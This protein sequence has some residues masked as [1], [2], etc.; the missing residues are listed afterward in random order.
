MTLSHR[1]D[2]GPTY[3][4]RGDAVAAGNESAVL[5]VE[6][7]GSCWLL[8]IQLLDDSCWQH[9]SSPSSSVSIPVNMAATDRQSSPQSNMREFVVEGENG[10]KETRRTRPDSGRTTSKTSAET[11]KGLIHSNELFNCNEFYQR[12]PLTQ[13]YEE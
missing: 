6:L 1:T 8:L 10:S 2:Q 13:F 9:F 4:Q 3:S 7:D 5:D 11:G 12:K